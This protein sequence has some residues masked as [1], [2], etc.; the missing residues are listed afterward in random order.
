MLIFVDIMSVSVTLRAGRDDNESRPHAHIE[1][2]R[3]LPRAIGS[4]ACADRLD[5]ACVDELLECILRNPDMSADVDEPD[6]MFRDHAPREA[7]RR[8]EE[9]GGFLSGE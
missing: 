3:R 9:R 6:S 4:I 8:P 1:A 5:D 2:Q 7:R